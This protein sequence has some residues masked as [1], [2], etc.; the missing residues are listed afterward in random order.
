VARVRAARRGSA[1]DAA[2]T[3]VRSVALGT[4]TA[5]PP[6]IRAVEGDATAC[7]ICD[8][9][10]AELGWYRPSGAA[11]HGPGLARE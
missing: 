6:P 8:V 4:D 5:M 3:A 2:L 7:E 10:R 11:F 9:L 1:M